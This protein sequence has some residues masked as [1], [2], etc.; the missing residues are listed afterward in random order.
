MRFIRHRLTVAKNK[1][2]SWLATPSRTFNRPDSVTL[3]RGGVYGMTEK[4]ST[5]ASSS[6]RANVQSISSKRKIDRLGIPPTAEAS[7]A[8]SILKRYQIK[9]LV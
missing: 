1:I 3:D 4:S 7:M 9:Y 6:L 8:S 2:P 5:P